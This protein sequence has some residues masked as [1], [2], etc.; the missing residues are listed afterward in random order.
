MKVLVASSFF[1]ASKKL[2][3]N[4]KNA[5]DKAVKVVSADPSLGKAKAGDLLGIY[6]YKFKVNGIEW[7]L[8]YRVVSSKELKLLIV[9]P[10]ENFYRDLKRK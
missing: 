3:P 6:I 10:H 5:L 2:H 9:G 7:L 1:R 8:A 4:Q